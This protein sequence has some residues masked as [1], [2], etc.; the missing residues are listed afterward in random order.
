MN[1]LDKAC[2]THDAVYYDSKDLKK[3]TIADK[4]FKK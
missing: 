2:F 1:E 3:R 4:N